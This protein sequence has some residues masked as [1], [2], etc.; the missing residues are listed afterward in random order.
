MGTPCT[1]SILHDDGSVTGVYCHS[2]GYPEHVGVIL[3]KH[4]RERRRVKRL[5]AMGNIS[6]L[7]PST[8]R[9]KGHTFDHRTLGFT[10]AYHRDRGDELSQYHAKSPA[11]FLRRFGES[12]N[13]MFM[14]DLRIWLFTRSTMKKNDL[15]GNVLIKAGLTAPPPTG[16]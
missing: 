5:I 9:P 4:F 16:L 11:Q 10:L 15:L 1:I 7:E 3:F 8:R 14:E 6:I 2:D 13:Y 12:Y